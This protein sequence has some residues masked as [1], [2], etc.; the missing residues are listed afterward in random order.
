MSRVLK[1]VHIEGTKAGRVD[2]VDFEP[3]PEK[4]LSLGRDPSCIL[5]FDPYEDPRVWAHHADIVLEAES[6]WLVDKGSTNGTRVNGLKIF[7]RSRLNPG[8]EIELGRKGA[9]FRVEFDD[10]NGE[11]RAEGEQHQRGGAAAG[12]DGGGDDNDRDGKKDDD[13][14][15]RP[16]DDGG[17]KKEPETDPQRRISRKKRVRADEG[18]GGAPVAA[19]A[20]AGGGERIDIGDGREVGQKTMHLILRNASDL[21]KREGGGSLT[22]V[23][24]V[25][26]QVASESSASVRV[27]LLGMT[28]FLLIIFGILLTLLIMMA[29]ELQ[30][31]RDDVQRLEGDKGELQSELKQLRERHD[32]AQRDDDLRWRDWEERMVQL[33]RAPDDVRREI[34]AHLQSSEEA[35][36]EFRRRYRAEYR[37][38]QEIHDRY[39]QSVYLVVCQLELRDEEG[40]VVD[41]R[42]TSGTGFLITD[43]G[44]LVTNKHVVQPWKFGK[45]RARIRAEDLEVGNHEL[46]AWPAGSHVLNHGPG[47]TLRD[48]TAFST[49]NGKLAL[50]RIA[51]DRWEMR[52]FAEYGRQQV[53]RTNDNFDLAILKLAEGATPYVPVPVWRGQQQSE[54]WR[55]KQLDRVMAVGF[56]RGTEL[57]DS[58][59][60]HTQPSTGDI[61][62]ID[63]TISISAP[64]IQGNSGGPVFTIN[65]DTDEGVVI[66]VV[67]RVV[68]GTETLGICIRIEHALRL[69]GE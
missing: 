38:F 37:A 50:D 49:R 21:T 51:D 6:F 27:W 33:E 2:D 65:R 36:R 62:S 68:S 18:P 32:E 22:F 53:H 59:R 39:R 24:E 10:L 3:L 47:R 44:H 48:D 14:A 56:P 67:T 40:N 26:R 58:T 9:R 54:G 45:L 4:T 42:T 15:K 57:L 12:D 23:R 1:L 30:Q 17:A 31:H 11:A 41:T 20:G 35:L 43:R 60:A 52:R 5:A 8:D 46:F 55:P 61:R 16:N 34:E 64:T 7:E 25:V 63:N 66:G 29:S 28:V 13:E 69:L 19:A